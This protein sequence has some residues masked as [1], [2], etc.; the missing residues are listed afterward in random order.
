MIDAA[1]NW[2]VQSQKEA[3]TCT[4]DNEWQRLLSGPLDGQIGMSLRFNGDTISVGS[5]N[6]DA[7]EVA[8]EGEPCE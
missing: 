6:A 8:D 5:F 1:D 2:V 7:A 4:N 3:G